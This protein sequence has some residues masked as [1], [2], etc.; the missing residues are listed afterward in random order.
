[1]TRDE[2]L[3]G[4][5]WQYIKRGTDLPHAKLNEDAV[6]VIRQNR[7]GKTAKQLAAEYGVHQRTIDKIR[8]RRSWSHIA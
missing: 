6:R 8:D 4:G 1:M 5:C 3:T 2:Y 7:H